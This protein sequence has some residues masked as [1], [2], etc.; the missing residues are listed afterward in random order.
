MHPAHWADYSK[1]FP[2]IEWEELMEGE[3][4]ETFYQK[5]RLGLT[6]N[7]LGISEAVSLNPSNWQL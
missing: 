4:G 1:K 2:C 6:I 3:A 7:W 5:P